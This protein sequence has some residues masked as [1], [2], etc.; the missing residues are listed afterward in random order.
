MQ[1]EDYNSMKGLESILEQDLQ[2]EMAKINTAGTINPTQIETLN[3]AVCLMLKLKEY[4]KWIN[5][6]EGEEEMMKYYSQ[7]GNAYAPMPMSYNP[8]YSPTGWSHHMP[9]APQQMTYGYYNNTSNHSTKDRMIS[10]LE[11]MMG[12]AKNEYEAK[13][14]RDAIT[15]IQ[16]N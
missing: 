15:Y 12:D 8:Y 1:K 11:D 13:M 16:S 2:K 10:K 14:I 5:S 6:P 4:E 7:Y 9:P 3:D